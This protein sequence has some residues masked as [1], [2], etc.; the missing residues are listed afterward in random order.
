KKYIK[1]I[2]KKN[3]KHFYNHGICKQLCTGCLWAGPE[4]EEPRAPG[5]DRKV[6]WR[7]QEKEGQGF[8]PRCSLSSPSESVCH[9]AT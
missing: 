4:K 9:L 2:E 6:L 7:G 8:F 3:V 5:S 1:L